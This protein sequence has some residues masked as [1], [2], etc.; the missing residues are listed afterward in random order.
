MAEDFHLGGP[1][2]RLTKALAD[3][4][5]RNEILQLTG[6]IAVQVLGCLGKVS[7]IRSPSS[8]RVLTAL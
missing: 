1:I 7:E 6:D 8:C 4:P 5:Q 2:E 3:E